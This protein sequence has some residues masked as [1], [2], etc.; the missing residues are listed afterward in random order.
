MSPPGSRVLWPDVGLKGTMNRWLV[1]SG[2]PREDI[3]RKLR[4]ADELTAAG[5]T[6]GEIAAELLVDP[7]IGNGRDGRRVTGC[8]QAV[9]LFQRGQH[10]VM[11]DRLAICAGCHVR[12]VE[13][14]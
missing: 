10:V 3:V 5:K 14:G 2:I 9:H 13:D 7:D 4:R 6:G 11:G 8:V 1:G 12:A